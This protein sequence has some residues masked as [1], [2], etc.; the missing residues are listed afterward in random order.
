MPV[1]PNG[2]TLMLHDTMA[3]RKEP[4]WRLHEKKVNMYVCGVTVYDCCIGH[5]RLRCLR[6]PLPAADPHGVRRH[7]LP[8]LYRVDDKIIKRANER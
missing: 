7:L 1:A 4:F 6:R 5:A 3:R 2:Q 8:Q